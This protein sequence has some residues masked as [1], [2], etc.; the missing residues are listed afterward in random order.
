MRGLSITATETQ[1]RFS[2]CFTPKYC[3]GTLVCTKKKIRA[4]STQRFSF[5]LSGHPDPLAAQT[6]L[7]S[8][9]AVLLFRTLYAAVLV[10]VLL[11]VSPHLGVF[12]AC[13]CAKHVYK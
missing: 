11:R 6:V 10:P 5:V 3:K 2:P 1:L 13:M 7:R 8:H 12:D 9:F 4:L